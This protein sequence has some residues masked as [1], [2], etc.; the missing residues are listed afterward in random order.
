M[1]IK[2]STDGV[3]DEIGD[4]TF[5]VGSGEHIQAGNRLLDVAPREQRL[6][7]E[8]AYHASEE[9]L[10]LELLLVAGEGEQIVQV[11]GGARLL[12]ERAVGPTGGE[13]RVSPRRVRRGL[14]EVDVHVRVAH[15]AFERVGADHRHPR[16]GDVPAGRVL[17]AL[18]ERCRDGGDGE[19]VAHRR[20]SRRSPRYCASVIEP[21]RR[22]GG[23]G[24]GAGWTARTSIR[25]IVTWIDDGCA[26]AFA[27]ASAG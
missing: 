8:R 24:A 5:E 14:I 7:V 17:Q 20:P 3:A 1:V 13:I 6:G 4:A 22:G 15:R 16:P 21:T 12:R 11:E 23:G 2:Q 10:G 25:P 9:T 26:T 18:A 19:E 27:L